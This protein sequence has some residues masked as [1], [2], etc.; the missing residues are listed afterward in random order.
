M[1]GLRFLAPSLC[2]LFGLLCVIWGLAASS[3]ALSERIGG[4]FFGVLFILLAYMYVR[5]ILPREQ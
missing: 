1:S 5:F 2:V 4:A 3:T